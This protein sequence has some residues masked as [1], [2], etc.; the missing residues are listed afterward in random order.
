MEYVLH[1]V[2]PEEVL[3]GDDS[4]ENACRFLNEMFRREAVF[5][6]MF[7]TVEEDQPKIPALHVTP[8]SEHFSC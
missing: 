8:L 3:D 6:S 5:E 4:V 2:I 1:V 7:L